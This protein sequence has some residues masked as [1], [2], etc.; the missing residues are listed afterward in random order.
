MNHN[1]PCP[2]CRKRRWNGSMTKCNF[3]GYEIPC[4]AMEGAMEIRDGFKKVELGDHEFAK[5]LDSWGD[6]TH[7]SVGKMNEF[8]VDGVVVAYVIYDNSNCTRETF[9]RR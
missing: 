8:I 2:R 6:W 5:F 7:K 4:R 3:C 1:K 9:I